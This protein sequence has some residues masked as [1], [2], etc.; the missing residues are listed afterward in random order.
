MSCGQPRS[1]LCC[2]LTQHRDEVS[3]PI[4]I[5]L[6]YVCTSSEEHWKQRQD[7]AH[8]LRYA[9]NS[10]DWLALYR[11]LLSSGETWRWLIWSTLLNGRDEEHSNMIIP[12]YSSLGTRNTQKM[13]LGHT[14]S[15]RCKCNERSRLNGRIQAYVGSIGHL[16][17]LEHCFSKESAI[18]VTAIYRTGPIGL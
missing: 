7:S 13:G 12:P 15:A 9:A 2:C 6:P 17:M 10:G 14:P 4:S 3:K 5:D 1:P 16:H 11:A 8:L 18:S